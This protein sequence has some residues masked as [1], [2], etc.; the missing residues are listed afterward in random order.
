MASTAP[1]NG[2]TVTT[3]VLFVPPSVVSPPAGPPPL[4]VMMSFLAGTSPC[5]IA[6]LGQTCI[7]FTGSGKDG[8][9]F[10]TSADGKTWTA[11]NRAPG[12]PIAP[13]SSPAALITPGSNRL[14]LFASQTSGSVSYISTIDPNFVIW[15]EPPGTVAGSN[16]LGGTSPSVVNFNGS[17]HLFYNG[18]GS[19]GIFCITSPANFQNPSPPSQLAPV[20]PSGKFLDILPGTSPCSVVFGNQILLFYTS[21]GSSGVA[22]T[23]E[24]TATSTT[25]CSIFATSSSDGTTWSRPQVV[26]TAAAQGTSPTAVVAGPPTASTALYLFWPTASTIAVAFTLDGENWAPQG[27]FSQA[28]PS[29]G[30]SASAPISANG[31]PSVFWTGPN[32]G[33]KQLGAVFSSFTPVSLLS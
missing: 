30:T 9:W 31:L 5:A 23:T 3:P 8:V 29:A 19:N 33:T 27:T 12:L 18:A 16:V 24:T 28:A 17:N 10:S 26:G 22:T 11:V 32:A 4:K 25:V 6:Y 15:A 20:T 21:A 14:F 7:F 13:G 1:S 2:I